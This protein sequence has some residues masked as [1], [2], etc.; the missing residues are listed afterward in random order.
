MQEVPHFVLTIE[1]ERRATEEGSEASSHMPYYAFQ[2]L[3][4]MFVLVYRGN[5]LLAFSFV[6]M[7]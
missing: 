3:D 6:P 4:K 7:D 2:D 5:C 1:D